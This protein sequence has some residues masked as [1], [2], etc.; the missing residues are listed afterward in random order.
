MILAPFEMNETCVL[1]NRINDEYDSM[2]T[3]ESKL[4]TGAERQSLGEWSRKSLP[5][6]E[7]W[8]EQLRMSV[9]AIV[10]GSKRELRGLLTD[11]LLLLFSYLFVSFSLPIS[12]SFLLLS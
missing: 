3:T 2:R 6:M 4:N 1:L 11:I 5:P 9:L 12:F 7:D 10:G 8:L